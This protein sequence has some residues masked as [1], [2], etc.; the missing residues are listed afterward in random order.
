MRPKGIL[1]AAEKV[2][3]PLILP[4]KENDYFSLNGGDLCLD[5]GL[6]MGDPFLVFNNWQ[7]LQI[8]YILL[9]NHYFPPFFTDIPL[10]Q[11]TI[12]CTTYQGLVGQI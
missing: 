9:S 3:G 2:A 6:L 1:A 4:C 10:R 12:N 11:L 5:K 7:K 8:I